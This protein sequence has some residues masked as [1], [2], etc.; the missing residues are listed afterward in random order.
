[1]KQLWR[2]FQ[3]WR[4]SDDPQVAAA[5]AVALV[6]AS[7]TPFYP[8]YVWWAAGAD[9]MPY[10][11][12]TLCSFPLFLAVPSVSR[13]APLVGRAMLPI[14]GVANTMFCT[15]L[16]GAAAGTEL[17][18]LPCIALGAMLF[19]PAERWLRLALIALPI[20]VLFVLHGHYAAPPHLYSAEQYRAL[21]T[22]NL[23]SVATLTGFLGLVFAPQS[24]VTEPTAP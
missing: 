10:V 6:V 21:F 20:A 22:I 4:G 3:A 7:N 8:F 24:E 5:N 19:R 2:R 11:W 13:R 15:W 18:N 12:A 17:F 23:F 1:L 9:G 16:L 14:V